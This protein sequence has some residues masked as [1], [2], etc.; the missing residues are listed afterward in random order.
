[1]I[2]ESLPAWTNQNLLLESG[3]IYAVGYAEMSADRSPHY[4]SRAATVDAE[5][6][7]LSDA[8]ADF[9][10]IAQ[11]AMH[12]AGVDS[13]DFHEITTSLREVFTVQ[14]IRTED[15]ECRRYIRYGE[16]QDRMLNA[17]WV[18]VSASAASL[19]EAYRRTLA[20][21]YGIGTANEFSDL[22]QDELERINDH[23]RHSD[24]QPNDSYHSDS[25]RDQGSSSRMLASEL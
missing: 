25:L 6:Q 23:R 5:R 13:A 15:V 14:S 12:G 2:G 4:V 3:K 21:K 10:V 7:L 11:N 9:R 18:K 8:P 20:I 17:C 16:T 24:D 22:M 19:Q 1:M